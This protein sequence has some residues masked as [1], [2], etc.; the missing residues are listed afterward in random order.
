[1]A[2]VVSERFWCLCVCAMMSLGNGVG[3]KGGATQSHTAPDVY[4]MKRMCVCVDVSPCDMLS[5]V[6][7]SNG[8]AMRRHVVVVVAAAP[9]SRQLGLGRPN[10]DNMDIRLYAFCACA[11]QVLKQLK[12]IVKDAYVCV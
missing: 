12:E 8:C 10:T 7:P 9:S 6:K 3:L 4:R 11:Q 5:S 2:A 1:M